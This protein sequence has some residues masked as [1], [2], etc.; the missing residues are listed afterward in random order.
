[1][2]TLL[3]SYFL[4][5]TSWLTVLPHDRITTKVTWEREIAPIVQAR[6]VSCHSAGG[7]A[8]MP[9]TTYDEARPWA[10]AIKEEV[11]A[12]RMPKWPIVRGYGDFANDR[13]LSSFEIAL[14]AAWADGGAPEKLRTP[15]EELRTKNPNPEPGT[16]NREPETPT[17]SIAR[18]VPC[19]A[20]K[21][22]AG[23][24][25]GLRA[26]LGKGE[27][28]RLTAVHGDGRE[29]ILIWLRDYDP[30]FD[31]TFWLRRPLTI[32][33]SMRF[34]AEAADGCT[35]TALLETRTEK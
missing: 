3:T 27:S 35:L 9:L 13:S 33:S 15:N 30:R 19:D 14:I 22:P 24:L 4:L 2:G 18:T 31:E 21:L 8:P 6:C 26:K 10:K 1:M 25:I 17:P 28:L 23:R 11:L 5:L 7:K 29:E 34:R 16:G 32:A 12:R 20:P